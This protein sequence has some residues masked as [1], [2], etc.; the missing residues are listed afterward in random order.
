ML[1]ILESPY[2]G[3]IDKNENYARE[4]MRDS[5]MRGEYP[6]A[7]HLLYT[8]EG[9]LNDN[10]PSERELGIRAGFTWGLYADKVVMY[11]DFGISE[12]MQQ[13]IDYWS[14]LGKTIEIRM[15]KQEREG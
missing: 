6:L 7:S 4:C 3:D 13:A 12:G 8:Q 5:L 10:N 1:V 9:I 15:I 14:G 11:F 2:A